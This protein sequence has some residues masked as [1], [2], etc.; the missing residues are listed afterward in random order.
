MPNDK[1]LKEVL[2]GSGLTQLDR[3]L[4]ILSIKPEEPLSVKAI[5][6]IGVEYGIRSISKWNFSKILGGANGKAIQTPKGWEITSIGIEHIE[7]NLNVTLKK[8]PGKQIISN[9]RVYLSQIKDKDT[10]NFVEESI[11]C[12]E[13][14]LFRSAVVL[15]WTGA[16]ALLY[17]YVITY[18]LNNFNVECLRRNPKWKSVNTKDDFG[19]IKESEFLEIIV[20]ISVI[21]KDVKRELLNCLN[22]RNSCGHPNSLAIADNRVAAH[23]E[24]LILN[25]FSKFV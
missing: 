14:N 9:L 19:R 10:Q 4:I 7:N 24:I 20:A 15:S 21:G 1:I 6:K 11:I 23:I 8:I 3:I 17:D 5:K 18:E 22:L 13:H 25:V 12:F 2:N 16:I